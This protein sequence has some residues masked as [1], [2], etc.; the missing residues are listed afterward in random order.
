MPSKSIAVW[1][2][3]EQAVDQTHEVH[4]NYWRMGEAGSSS[5]PHCRRWLSSLVKRSSVPKAGGHDLLELGVWVANPSKVNT[6][7]AYLPLKIS[8][9]DIIDCSGHF[10]NSDISQAIF[11]EPVT[12]T[13]GPQ[14]SPVI[15]AKI[16]DAFY[17]II[18]SFELSQGGVISDA[19]L[20]ILEKGEG[21]QLTIT[22]KAIRSA[23]EAS[24]NFEKLYFR[25]RVNLHNGSPFVSTIKPYDGAL[26]SGYEEI[27]YIDFRVNETRSLPREVQEDL[28]KS[29]SK[30]SKISFLTAAPISL[31]LSSNDAPLHK[32]RVLE[33]TVW[34]DYVDQL[35]PHMMVYHWRKDWRDG[36]SISDFSGFAKFAMRRSGR[37]RVIKYLMIFMIISIFSSWLA[38]RFDANFGPPNEWFQ[39]LIFEVSPAS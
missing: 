11:N 3:G 10:K 29:S 39:R 4:V 38:A 21:V 16:N 14:K 35:P 24:G 9:A 6:V 17:T 33:S 18:F 7:S 22:N 31:G 15:T 25:I 27:D 26:Q 8:R 5:L 28:R 30:L 37:G 20:D 23:Q 2:T 32:A 34:G 19:E 1:T 12:I 36:L 13:H